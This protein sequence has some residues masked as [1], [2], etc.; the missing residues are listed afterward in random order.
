MP[1]IEEHH[2]VCILAIAEDVVREAEK[3][4][5]EKY[6]TPKTVQ[7][8]DS[9]KLYILMNCGDIPLI[10]SPTLAIMGFDFSE[11]ETQDDY[12]Y[13][14]MIPHLGAFTDML[15]NIRIELEVNEDIDAAIK[16]LGVL[17][18]HCAKLRNEVGFKREQ[19]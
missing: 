9:E 2:K 10:E 8:S 5:K 17:R 19:G 13:A 11:W 12:D 16:A 3:L 4:I 1:K 18:A 15:Y 7:L 14:A 6:Y